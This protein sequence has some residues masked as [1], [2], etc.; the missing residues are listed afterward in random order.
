MERKARTLAHIELS[1]AGRHV[2]SDERPLPIHRR[3]LPAA[4]KVVT[5]AAY[6]EGGVAERPERR[7]LVGA[8]SWQRKR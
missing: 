4:R 6:S 8:P 7:I 3:N 2:L 5:V 1:M